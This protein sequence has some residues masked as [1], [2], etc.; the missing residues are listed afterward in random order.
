MC[1][2]ESSLGTTHEA[3]K[4][5][6]RLRKARSRG[7][8][9][10]LCVFVGVAAERCG[11]SGESAGTCASTSASCFRTERPV[12]VL[13]RRQ[14]WPAARSRPLPAHPPPQSRSGSTVVRLV[15]VSCG[16]GV[17]NKASAYVADDLC[18]FFRHVIV[19]DLLSDL[20]Q[21]L[22]S[23]LLKEDPVRVFVLCVCVCVC[24]RAQEKAGSYPPFERLFLLSVLEEFV[25]GIQGKQL[26]L[27]CARVM[28]REQLGGKWGINAKVRVCNEQGFSDIH[29][30]RPG[31][32]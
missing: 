2:Y 7:K 20:N 17:G 8:V 27:C 10:C 31:G 4:T 5:D 26:K 18:R 9:W 1:I 3:G 28:C 6:V 30:P 16:C 12:Q 32:F 11:N 24:V 19:G 25:Q 21:L 15:C 13:P 23:A 22:A 14:P 29:P